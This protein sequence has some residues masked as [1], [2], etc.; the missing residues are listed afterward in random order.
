MATD[1][2]RRTALRSA[3]VLTF[4]AAALSGC[5]DGSTTAQLSGS[6]GGPVEV[7]V[8]VI[9]I[10]DVAPLYLG[11]QKGIFTRHGLEV[12][13]QAA[14]GGAAIVPA[15]LSGQNQFGFSNVVSLLTA[16]EKGVPLLSVAGGV[17]ST[18]D[19]AAD[20]NAVLV[21]KDSLLR[22]GKDL[23]GHK[24][25]INTLNNIGDTTVKSAVAKAGGD[26]AKV[27]FVEIAFPDMAAQLAAGRVDAAWA[28]EPFVS[29]IKAAGGRVLLDSL[30]ETYPTLQVAQWFTSEQLK[31]RN[32]DLIARFTAAI[33]E[34]MTYASGH[35]EEVRAVL[36]TYTKIGAEVAAKVVLPKWP[37]ELDKAS[38]TAVGRAAQ[39][40]GTLKQAPDVDGLFGG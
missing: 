19:P 2:S 25:A 8:G 22:T 9:P 18:G 34:S 4:G 26:P 21:G 6:G 3:F 5:S 39:T 33:K 30:T 23:E 1:L 7:S 38:T 12:S 29:Q 27:G 13:A 10:L 31:Q 11:I 15:V 40:Y 16:R 35:A 20:F 24:V 36:T 28:S 32:P 14:Q 17:S 37:A